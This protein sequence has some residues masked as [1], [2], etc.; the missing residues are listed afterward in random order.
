MPVNFSL[1]LFIFLA[2]K[3]LYE[4][5]ELLYSKENFRADRDFW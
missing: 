4:P 3:V 2:N 1:I 5:S